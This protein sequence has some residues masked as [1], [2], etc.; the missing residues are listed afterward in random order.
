M[1]QLL[2]KPLILEALSTFAAFY[3]YLK[4]GLYSIS[5]SITFFHDSISISDLLWKTNSIPIRMRFDLY[6]DP[7]HIEEGKVVDG[8][9][10]NG[11]T[12]FS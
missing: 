4:P 2:P 1:C 11:G 10:C 12:I 7:L 5:I 9:Y 8:R 6:P 3:V